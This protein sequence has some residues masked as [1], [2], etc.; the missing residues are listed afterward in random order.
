MKLT[1]PPGARGGLV[2]L[3]GAMTLDLA[4]RDLVLKTGRQFRFRPAAANTGF[5]TPP[6]DAKAIRAVGDA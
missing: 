3:A 1:P 5:S 6:D 2:L 4:P